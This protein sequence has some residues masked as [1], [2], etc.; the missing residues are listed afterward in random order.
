MIF[1]VLLCDFTTGTENTILSLVKRIS[2]NLL[3]NP[4][5]GSFKQTTTLL[6]KLRVG[7]IVKKYILKSP[8]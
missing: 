2:P 4:Y 8:I 7:L 1:N 6:H 3:K 5:I